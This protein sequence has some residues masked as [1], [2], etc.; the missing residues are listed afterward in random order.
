MANRNG[1]DVA[2]DAS[3]SDDNFL[4][5]EE[6]VMSE[7]EDFKSDSNAKNDNARTNSR[8]AARAVLTSR[9]TPS[10]E[11][12]A[13]P[14]AIETPG[15]P[16]LP[17]P[18]V[19]SPPAGMEEYA[20]AGLLPPTSGANV[21]AVLASAQAMAPYH[22]ANS[23][24]SMPA[25]MAGYDEAIN[26]AHAVATAPSNDDDEDS[27]SAELTDREARK[28]LE[29]EE[30]QD[31][32]RTQKELD[33]M[34]EKQS[35]NKYE[36]I[37]EFVRPEGLKEDIT[38]YPYQEDGIRWLLHQETNE[39]RI[40]P[41]WKERTLGA[42]KNHWWRCSLT[43]KHQKSRPKSCTGSILAGT[44]LSCG[45]LLLLS[46]RH[47]KFTHCLPLSTNDRRHGFGKDYSV[48]WFDSVQYAGGR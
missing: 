32:K 1:D 20:A 21:D 41:F 29:S 13:N 43:G 2:M 47:H 10:P 35:E 14:S 4:F 44:C 8:R 7:D 31:W 48:Y 25:A 9:V 46:S 34:F 19:Q 37:P 16:E 42:S 23:F 3:T 22:Y 18:P 15:P 28:L 30:K 12:G 40:P 17:S 27:I 38:F 5:D 6:E 36:G 39:D 24:G 26:A 11:P 45:C 33:D